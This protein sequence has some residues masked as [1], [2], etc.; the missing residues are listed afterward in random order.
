MNTFFACFTVTASLIAASHAARAEGPAPSADDLKHGIVTRSPEVKVDKVDHDR[1]AVHRIDV[2]DSKGVI[3]ATLAAQDPLPVIGGVQYKRVFPAA[4]LILFDRDGNERGGFAVADIEGSAVV[5]A[6]DH[7]NGDAIGWRAMPD[8]AV[9]FQINERA[10]VLRDTARGN[11]L[12]GQGTQRIA[13]SVAADGTPAIALQD[14]ESRPRLR[15]TLTP[16][17]FG[18]IEFL[19]AAGHVVQTFAPEA[20]KQRP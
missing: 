1:I 8:G 4:G 13:M 19:D 17:G 15:L 12:P 10:P 2:V 7:T 11:V 14:R 20:Q 18:A 9:T 3:R 16:E 6:V 5:T